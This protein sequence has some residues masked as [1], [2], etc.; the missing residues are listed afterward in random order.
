[1]SANPA[2]VGAALGPDTMSE[3]VAIKPTPPS[4]KHSDLVDA[5]ELTIALSCGEA[6]AQRPRWYTSWTA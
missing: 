2:E 6:I 1:M 5:R 4:G 3:V